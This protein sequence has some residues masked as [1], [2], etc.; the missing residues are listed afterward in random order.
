M[1]TSTDP[2]TS[3]TSVP[4]DEQFELADELHRAAERGQ[5]E[6]IN[7]ILDDGIDVNIRDR[8]G[9]T[10]LHWAKD[11][12]VGKALLERNAMIDAHTRTGYSPLH[13]AARHGDVELVELLIEHGADVNAANRNFALTPL[14]MAVDDGRI[15]VASVLISNGADV[16]ATDWIGM[17]PLA[18]AAE[19]GY[20]EMVALLTKYGGM[21]ALQPF[22]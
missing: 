1:Q 10:A 22:E 21:G 5:P 3:D 11:Q 16:N 12:S 13:S 9:K 14:H 17:T 18:M 15:N 19:R 20:E 4:S 7:R 6:N 8:D 2:S